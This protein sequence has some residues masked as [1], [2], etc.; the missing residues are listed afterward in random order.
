[1][2]LVERMGESVEHSE[3]KEKLDRCSE[4]YNRLFEV[5]K[6]ADASLE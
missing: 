6:A 2:K 1:L 4:E 3:I 5:A